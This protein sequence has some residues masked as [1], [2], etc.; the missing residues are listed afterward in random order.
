MVEGS[1][2]V[3][4]VTF[5]NPESGYAVVQLLPESAEPDHTVTA[6]GIFGA[7]QDGINYRVQGTW[8]HDPRYGAQIR[9]TSAIIEKPT[10]PAAVE[11]YLAGASIKGLGPHHARLIVEH[12]GA[13]VLEVLDQ[14]G[15]RLEEVRGIGPVRAAKIRAS[16]S[17]H[18]S[19]NRLMV[20]LQGVAGMTPRQAQRIYREF[21]DDAWR[22]VSTD[23]Y[24]LAERVIG[25][26]FRTC[27][28]IAGS[29]GL[30]PMAPQRLQA[31]ILHVMN[32]ALGDGHLW[33]APDELLLAASQLLETE[34]DTLQPHLATLVAQGRV[35]KRPVG[36]P[37]DQEGVY[38]P[39]VAE[40]ENRTASRLSIWMRQPPADGLKLSAE[41]ATR[42][43]SQHSDDRL[44]GEQH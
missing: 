8:H 35:V 6:T 42:L 43:V 1:F 15:K 9:V 41:S 10:T 27:D 4:R 40:T 39:A 38:L 21:G 29:L 28:R 19:I 5:A 13:D 23:P 12:F 16:W 32:E 36:G 33:T 7:V 37:Q 14:G 3:E 20:N 34:A 11:R 30:E 18:Q 26:G 17:E 25:F 44:T 31:G 2:C 22:V 24:L